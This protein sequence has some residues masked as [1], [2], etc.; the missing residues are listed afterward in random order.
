MGRH[1]NEQVISQF[2][3]GIS[4]GLVAERIYGAYKEIFDS[5][6]NHLPPTLQE[7][8][9]DQR[10]KLLQFSADLVFQTYKH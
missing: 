2:V 9:S 5:F 8:D 6:D 10:E 7:L 3:A 1:T 4:T